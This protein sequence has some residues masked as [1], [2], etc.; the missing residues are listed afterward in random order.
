[1]KTLTIKDIAE[2]AGVSVATVSRVINNNGRFSEETR[3]KVLDIIEK[4]G[5]KTNYMAKSLRTNKSYT[6]GVIVPDI[7]NYFFF[8]IVEKVEQI[9]FEKN[10]TTI[11]CNTDRSIKKEKAYLELLESKKIDG[12][13][14][15]SGA[16][17]FEFPQNKIPYVC[18]DREP[19]DKSKT[20]FISSN[21]YKGG[22]M[23]TKELIKRGSKNPSIVYYNDKATYSKNRI[24]GFEA[25]LKDENLKISKYSKL[26]S[27]PLS[28]DMDLKKILKGKVDSIF[29]INDNVAMDVLL[30]LNE[31]KIKVPDD[32]QV[33]GFD[34]NINDKYMYPSLSTIRQNVEEIARNSVDAL[35]KLMNQEEK[36]GKSITIDVDLVLRNSTKIL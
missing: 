19:I 34:D 14:V 25:A 11:I 3:K 6:I 16:E 24:S 23:A 15:I 8:S 10:F 29:A 30:S 28:I 12:L 7:S 35:I 2:L 21:H 5:Y 26:K 36:P 20:I 32:V 9:M 33:I 1:M 27:D 4:T 31:N 18:I 13:I 22:Y 17:N